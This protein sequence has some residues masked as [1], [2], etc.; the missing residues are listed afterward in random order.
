MSG[1]RYYQGIEPG[2]MKCQKLAASGRSCCLACDQKP[3][4]GSLSQT[5]G[6]DNGGTPLRPSARQ[7]SPGVTPGEVVLENE[8]KCGKCGK[9]FKHPKRLATHEA[10]CSGAKRAP[11]KRAPAQRR[12]V[13]AG[14]PGDLF[15]IHLNPEA[16]LGQL[17]KQYPG[18]EQA[19]IAAIAGS[20]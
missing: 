12:A 16:T 20:R 9:L 6:L 3:E 19:I 5:P 15:T 4:A 1:C 10:T 11:A 14:A 7:S 17:V 13:Q 8:L 2:G 18:V